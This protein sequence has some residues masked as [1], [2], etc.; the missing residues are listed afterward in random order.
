M[1]Q[2]IYANMDVNTK[3]FE[4]KHYKGTPFQRTKHGAKY[5]DYFTDDLGK[6]RLFPSE[7]IARNSVNMFPP[8]VLTE[9]N[10]N[11]KIVKIRCELVED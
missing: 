9:F 3:Q 8:K 10:V 4:R 6:A 5:E 7:K 11:C 2:L 1:G